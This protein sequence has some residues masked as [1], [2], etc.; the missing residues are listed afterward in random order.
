MSLKTL[1]LAT[2]VGLGGALFSAGLCISAQ[3]QTAPTLSGQVS[4]TEEGAMEGVLVSAKKEGS[5]IAKTMV[6]DD[7]GR[8]SF[9]AANL[10]P[11]T[12]VITIRAAGYDLLGPKR[13]EI[14]A[15]GAT[16]DLRLAKTRNITAQLS[17]AE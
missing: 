5:T 7:K 6:T 10:E 12:Y 14:A 11:G 3:A 16:A 15:A 13:V 17:N 4:S 2:T 1:L 9:A 8:F